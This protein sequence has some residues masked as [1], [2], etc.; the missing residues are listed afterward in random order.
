MISIAIARLRGRRV[1]YTETGFQFLRSCA[2][3]GRNKN[4]QIDWA[5]REGVIVTEPK[6]GAERYQVRWD[7]N[8]YPEPVIAKFLELL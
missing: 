6:P 5:N 4:T 7:G 2:A 1:K 8:T 3:R